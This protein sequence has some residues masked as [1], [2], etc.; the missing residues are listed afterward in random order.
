MSNVIGFLIGIIVGGVM[1]VILM[2]LM[3]AAGDYDRAEEG[4]DR[5]AEGWESGVRYGKR[6]HEE[7]EEGGQDEADYRKE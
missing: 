5:F 6:F 2:G 7:I 4:N 1:G 3:V